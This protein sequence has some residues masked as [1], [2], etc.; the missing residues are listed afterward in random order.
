MASDKTIVRVLAGIEDLLVSSDNTPTTQTRGTATVSVTPI[1]GKNIPYDPS[2]SINQKIDSEATALT[3]LT[4]RV[5]TN[6]TT[7]STETGRITNNANAISGLTTRVSSAETNIT[8]NDNDISSLDTRVTTAETNITSNDGDIT[9]LQT[10]VT[11]A[12][13]DITGNTTAITALN[14]RVTTAETDVTALDTRV[15]SAETNITTNTTNT[16]SN[17]SSISALNNRV[18]ALTP[19]GTPQIVK[20]DPALT[21]SV[22][23]G[24]TYTSL[25]S[26]IEDVTSKYYP[27]YKDGIVTPVTINLLSGYILSEPLHI[28][29]LDLSWITI[30]GADAS[31]EVDATNANFNTVFNH[32]TSTSRA[33][34]IGLLNSTSPI[35]S[36]PFRI[37]D[38][39]TGLS[40]RFFGVRAVNSRV[41]IKDGGIL[42]F[43]GRASRNQII[44]AEGS[45]VTIDDS[46]FEG[47]STQSDISQLSFTNSTV[48]LRGST[49]TNGGLSLGATLYDINVT[50]FTSSSALN[51]IQILNGSTG[52]INA[53]G[54]VTLTNT[55]RIFQVTDS[56]VYVQNFPALSNLTIPFMTLTR[57]KVSLGTVGTIT[58]DSGYS[59]D[60]LEVLSG[61]VVSGTLPVPEDRINTAVNVINEN[62]VIF[63]TTPNKTASPTVNNTDIT[64]GETTAGS[65]VITNYNSNLLYNI[66]SLDESLLTLQRID[67]TINI[68]AGTVSG[69][70]S[71][72]IHI[73]ATE[74]GK[75]IS[76]VTVVTV[77]ILNV[78]VVADDAITITEF[79]G[80]ATTNN[81]WSLV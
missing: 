38:D 13:T 46:T 32:L 78:P 76:D 36:Q 71:V 77:N 66:Q 18:D 25:N 55:T 31:T 20:V 79:T 51:A 28:Y 30:T 17:T 41:L 52:V 15:T 37:S 6:E 9:A 75:F 56:N 4:N 69:A 24:G 8:N 3:T 49:I 40:S 22:G 57:G 60:L 74:G 14:T 23:T 12:E 48:I 44:N 16:A 72:E 50:S 21:F 11:T 53:S 62:G 26:A 80:E 27:I 73:F 61:S 67:D 34:L 58:A 42:N 39:I 65:V 54:T 43:S 7:I 64:L 47:R 70:E 10:R 19:S 45:S 35:I 59:G 29:N 63:G 2:S 33:C 68:T 1:S 81:N 5:T